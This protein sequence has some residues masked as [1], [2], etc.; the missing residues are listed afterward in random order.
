MFKKIFA[1]LT[2][3]HPFNSGFY[4]T[5]DGHKIY[6]EEYGNPNATPLI[7]FHGG[8]G[9]KIKPLHASFYP[10]RH[11]HLILFDQRGCGRS[12]PLA[13]IESNTTD[14]ILDDANE[15]L[16]YLNVKEKVISIGNSWG[17]TLALLFAE[18]F[19]ERVRRIIVSSVFLARAQDTDEGWFKVCS[20]FYPDFYDRLQ[21][22][23]PK[24]ESISSYCLKLI[25]SSDKL[26]QKLAVQLSTGF[27]HLIGEVNPKLP[28]VDEI[29]DAVIAGTKIYIHFIAN[30]YFIEEN[31]ILKNAQKI[32][33]IETLIVHNRLDMTCAV[34]QAF[35]LH[36]ALPKSRLI[37]VPES[38]HGGEKLKNTVKKEIRRGKLYL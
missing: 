25:N 23:T 16:N 8:P 20:N 36:N 1:K 18:K 2:A 31:Q 35:E 22:I 24:D 38:G 17:S 33:N 30:G 15:L 6:F 7:S 11:C 26:E 28:E 21:S 27:E 3:P 5:T 13:S 12:T 9:S 10:L 32:K 4:E 34:K 29:D 14:K 37:I 19:P